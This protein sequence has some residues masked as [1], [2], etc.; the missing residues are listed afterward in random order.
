[1][2]AATD[3]HG[4]PFAL[5]VIRPWPDI[6]RRA[7]YQVLHVHGPP[8][9]LDQRSLRWDRLGPWKRVV[10]CADDG[11]Q[12]RHDVVEAI[13][14]ATVPDE[15]RGALDEVAAEFRVTVGDGEL[16]V[17]GPDLHA[18]AVTLNVVHSLVVE[19][20]DPQAA[21]E[22][23][24]RDLAALRDGRAPADADRL[25][26]ADDAPHGEPR[27]VELRDDES[28]GPAPGSGTT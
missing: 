20:L 26:F 4:R 7:A 25:H 19:G 22:R 6:A 24:F 21:R 5:D 17:H 28:P 2:D 11:D 16:T 18:N 3:P 12:D 15:R 10:V 13:I 23:R 1:M 8:H 9:E 27:T 14:E